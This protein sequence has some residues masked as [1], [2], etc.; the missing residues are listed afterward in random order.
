MGTTGRGLLGRLAM[1]AANTG[2]SIVRTGRPHTRSQPL[3]RGMAGYKGFGSFHSD[4]V[5]EMIANP[6][7]MRQRPPALDLSHL[8]ARAAATMVPFGAAAK[9]AYHLDPSWTFLNHGV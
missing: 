1:L 4:N 3:Q 9:P 7:A 5:Q 8:A 2:S 6:E